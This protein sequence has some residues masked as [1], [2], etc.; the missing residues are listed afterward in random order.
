MN[1]LLPKYSQSLTVEAIE[2]KPFN[3]FSVDSWRN[4]INDIR[5]YSETKG[6]RGQSTIGTEVGSFVAGTTAAGLDTYYQT[7]LAVT[8]PY[9]FIKGTYEFG[10]KAVTTGLPEIGQIIYEQPAYSLGYVAGTYYGGKFVTKTTEFTIN[11]LVEGYTR[12]TPSYRSVELSGIGE[13]TI[14]GVP[15][16][17]VKEKLVIKQTEIGGVTSPFNSKFS[18]VTEKI[19]QTYDIGL[20]PER[21][22]NLKVNPELIISQ[23]GKNIPLKTNPTLPKLT[24][25]QMDIVNIGKARGDIFSGSFAQKIFVKGSRKFKDIDILSLDPELTRDVITG[26]YDNIKFAKAKVSLQGFS[27]K[28]QIVDVVPLELGE[29]GYVKKYGYVE[30]EGLKIVNPKARLASKIYQFGIGKSKYEPK[31][32]ID[33]KQLTGGKLDIDLNKAT[34]TGPYGYTRTELGAYTGLTGPLT[35][36]ARGLFG[37]LKKETIVEN[38][39]GYGLFATP[40]DIKTRQPMTRITRLGIEGG[41]DASFLDV[42]SGD[43]T[44]RKTKPQIVIFE[45]QKIGDTFKVIYKSSELE[46][47]GGI[48]MIVKQKARLGTTIINGRRV[49]IISAEIGDV[50]KLTPETQSLFSK[51]K[52]GKASIIEQEDLFK[53]LEKETGISYSSELELKPYVSPYRVP[54]IVFYKE[55]KSQQ[56]S[57]VITSYKPASIK[58]GGVTSYS[59]VSPSSYK[60]FYSI[61][62]PSTP[63]YTPS[64]GYIPSQPSAPSKPSKPFYPSYPSYPVASIKTLPSPPTKI[65]SYPRQKISTPSIKKGRYSVEIRRFGKFK[66]IGVYSSLQEAFKRGKRKVSTTLA[67]TFR[68]RNGNVGTP[69]G[70][71]SKNTRG[72]RLYIE[73]PK[74]R[75]STGTEKM[76]IKGYKNLRKRQKGGRII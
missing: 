46:V 11:K 60:P 32:L 35:T 30:F 21:G 59:V 54:P 64:I 37:F 23:Y 76:E 36:S 20:I 7:K 26:T 19:P 66:N 2:K 65:I 29:A 45:N 49:P 3:L 39:K 48:G 10:K 58:Y 53:N 51:V 71:Y 70:F 57:Q 24:P 41:K 4:M 55:I 52:K 74:F 68:I 75:L 22:A 47:E 38:I 61:S 50:S 15:S 62:K 28:E 17:I 25:L 31:I 67:A 43:V 69:S 5:A 13:Q 63:S 9:Q 14:K 40:F 34:L 72:G 73:Q 16:S 27:G 12:L 8:N 1:E 42:I 33:I 6:F 56:P 44:F 18:L